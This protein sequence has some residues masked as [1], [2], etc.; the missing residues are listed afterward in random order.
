MHCHTNTSLQQWI[1]YGI[2][3][4]YCMHVWIHITET[5]L[6][7]DVAV[8]F[9][10]HITMLSVCGSVWASVV[11]L[12]VCVSFCVWWTS[13]KSVSRFK[14]V[15]HHL[16]SFP[17]KPISES[18]ASPLIYGGLYVFKDSRQNSKHIFNIFI[19]NYT[20]NPL[21]VLIIYKWLTKTNKKWRLFD[22]LTFLSSS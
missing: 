16:P 22:L 5:Y 11:S 14:I 6:C 7:Y 2:L 18:P 9:H 3:W 15:C 10:M 1:R 4:C 13:I 20:F 12:V 21:W 17:F 8:I 19:V